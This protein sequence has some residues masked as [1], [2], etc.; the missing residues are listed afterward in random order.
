[1]DG[2]GSGW[3]QRTAVGMGLEVDIDGICGPQ[4]YA[5]V[6]MVSICGLEAL[7][8][9]AGNA[10]LV[11]ING[12]A[13]L[14]RPSRAAARA[15][16]LMA[17]TRT[18]HPPPH[19]IHT[20]CLEVAEFNIVSMEGLD[21]VNADVAGLALGDVLGLD[22]F[23][24]HFVA[25]TLASVNALTDFTAYFLSPNVAAVNG[26]TNYNYAYA[27]PAYTYVESRADVP[28]QT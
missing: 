14:R 3:R 10:E 15:R 4:I 7:N 26:Q 21:V 28:P 27:S 23:N 24:A 19:R 11:E 16:V 5:G 17:S 1:M 18:S 6:A 22:L 25:P 8:L 2:S 9:E 20:L 12:C 13:H